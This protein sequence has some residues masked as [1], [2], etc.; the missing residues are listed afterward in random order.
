MRRRVIGVL[1]ICLLFLP[2]G[3]FLPAIAHVPEGEASSFDLPLHPGWNL[4]SSPLETVKSAAELFAPLDPNYLLFAYS[5]TT[6]GYLGKGQ[7]SLL[8]AGRGYW[9]KL[10]AT[11]SSL[12]LIG[13]AWKIRELHLLAGWNMIGSPDTQPV[14]WED[15]QVRNRSTSEVVPLSMAV[16]TVPGYSWLRSNFYAY[17]EDRYQD[18]QGQNLTPGCGY[19]VRVHPGFDLDLIFPLRQATLRGTILAFDQPLAGASLTIRAGSQLLATATSGLDG[20]YQA[21]VPLS[22][23]TLLTIALSCQLPVSPETTWNEEKEV[24]AEPGL[25]YQA[26]FNS[27]HVQ[28]EGQVSAFGQPAPGGIVSLRR[29]ATPLGSALIDDSGRFSVVFRLEEASPITISLDTT[30]LTDPPIH[31]LEEKELACQPSHRYTLSFLP[32]YAIA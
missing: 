14:A 6:G 19:W 18:I 13:E 8:E 3:A 22:V 20:S 15:L 32:P 10:S 23:L 28:V 26:D 30:T 16:S 17:D 11:P 4:L 1:L 24:L 21:T 29:G 27:R 25:T 9:L 31:W 5:P 12:S 7:I 2:S